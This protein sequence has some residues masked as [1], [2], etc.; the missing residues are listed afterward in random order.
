MKRKKCGKTFPSG[1]AMDRASF[2][3]SVLKNNSFQC[4][5]C[6]N[7]D[8]YDKSDMIYQD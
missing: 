1:I 3:T 4:H 2:E 8:V 6:K 7:V 5:F